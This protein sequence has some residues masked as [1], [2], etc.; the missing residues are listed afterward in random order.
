MAIIWRLKPILVRFAITII[1][2]RTVLNTNEQMLSGSSS[3]ISLCNIK[4]IHHDIKDYKFREE[5]GPR[6][7]L[8][9]Q[10]I[11]IQCKLVQNKTIPSL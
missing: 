8:Y 5:E 1:R 11:L 4:F 6:Q 3:S 2:R 10:K 7:S 9:A